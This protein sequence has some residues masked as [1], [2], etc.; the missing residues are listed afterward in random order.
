MNEKSLESHAA[1]NLRIHFLVSTGPRIVTRTA[2]GEARRE[3][4]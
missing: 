1:V 4:E 2:Y 3:R